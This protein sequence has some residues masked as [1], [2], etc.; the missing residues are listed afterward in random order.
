MGLLKNRVFHRYGIVMVL[1][2]IV[3][4]VY[5]RAIR[6]QHHWGGDFSVYIAQTQNLLE[7]RAFYS[8]SYVV[9][10]QSALNH[11]SAY[12]PVPSLL[13]APF[14]SVFGLNYRALKLGL[15]LFAWAS[16][17]F[18]YWLG[19]RLGL[20]P[21][22]SALTVLIFALGSLL[23]P[24]LDSVGSDGVN[25]LLTAAALLAIVWVEQ[26]GLAQRRPIVAAGLVSMLLLLCIAT[27]STSYALIAAFGLHRAWEAWRTR[28][29]GS[30][31]LWAL[32][33]VGTGF[34]IYQKL[35]FNSA[36]QYGTQ[37]S[38][39][40]PLILRGAI[41]YLRAGAP[42]WSS[43]PTPLRYLLAG[44][45]LAC[46]V[47]AF[48][49]RR[50][51][52]VEWY[53]LVFYGMLCLYTVSSDFRYILPVLPLLLFLAVGS[54]LAAGRKLMPSHATA[55]AW[56]LGALALVASGFNI[57]AMETGPVTEG[58]AKPGFQEVVA[59]LKHTPAD[60]LILSW[61]PRVFALYTRHPSALYPQQATSFEAEIPPARGVL[62][63][64]YQQPLDHQKLDAYLAHAP[65]PVPI[66]FSN[67]NFT[68]YQIR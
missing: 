50:W 64:E 30:Y 6:P 28:T 47:A 32:G 38:L 51:G 18:W 65:V 43:A 36:Q 27:R 62:L 37:F 26:D 19:C 24:I 41:F 59:F 8:S 48:V 66:V 52:I 14:Y 40:G 34:L 63:V 54:I 35:L 7:G 67:E 42:L 23:Y 12:A 16:L 9:T 17:P 61:N 15:A 33:M 22:V 3:A 31:T 4:P 68:V 29:I 46:A 10:P 2:A 56:L 45:L 58:I 39:D 53:I 25:L 13:M 44:S 1:L 55:P 60:T 49:R 21:P 20:P 57:A 11:P 5:V